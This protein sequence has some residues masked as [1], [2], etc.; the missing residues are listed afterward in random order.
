VT[1]IRLV[2]LLAKGLLTVLTGAVLGLGGYLLWFTLLRGQPNPTHRTLFAGVTYERLVRASP[3]PV[4]AHVVRIRAG[5]PGVRFLVTPP[6][7]AGGR[8]LRA[9]TT[10]DFLG[11]HRLQLAI[12]GD[13]F[14]P[15]YSATPWDFYPRRG[16]PVDVVGFAASR[17]QIY[18]PRATGRL[19]LYISCANRLSFQPSRNVCHAISGLPLLRQGR[20]VL[21]HH[22][23]GLHPRTALALDRGNE[24]LL[25]VAVDGRQPGYSEGATPRELAELVLRVGGY[26]AT[27]LDGGGSTAL[28]VDNNG[29]PLQLNAPIH[30][31]LVGRERP[32]A[33]HLGVWARPFLEAR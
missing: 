31:R 29:E 9:Q 8:Q 26:S 33:N 24:M 3:R 12:N 13:F 11:R 6:E 1:F 15:W 28:V 19:T 5:S 25:L 32:V 7:P 4:V 16:D 2:A 10:S 18:G 14:E 27:N 17:G 20:I 23:P 21:R 22:S 30:T